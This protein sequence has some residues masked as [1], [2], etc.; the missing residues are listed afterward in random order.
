MR[1]QRE[2]LWLPAADGGGDGETEDRNQIQIRSK[3]DPFEPWLHLQ[4]DPKQIQFR[5]KSD[6][7]EVFS[8]THSDP[9]QTQ[10]RSKSDPNQIPIRFR[11]DFD[12]ISIRFRSDFD[13][14]GFGGVAWGASENDPKTI[15]FGSVLGGGVGLAPSKHPGSTG[16]LRL[17]GV[18][19]NV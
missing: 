17:G 9:N 11:S 5:S 3:S 12:P 7:L 14:V 2:A 13:P 10:I 16:R 8:Q 15:R 18:I 6:P 19:C 1:S 4:S